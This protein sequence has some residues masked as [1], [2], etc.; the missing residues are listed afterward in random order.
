[1]KYV[2]PSYITITSIFFILLHMITACSPSADELY[3]EARLAAQNSNFEQAI[4]LYR[5]VKLA[6]PKQAEFEYKSQYGE[7]EVYRIQQKL[8]KQQAIL[9]SLFKE[10]KY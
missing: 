2:N 5:Q 9:E 6:A 10:E 1:M 3:N 4:D 8:A 7:S